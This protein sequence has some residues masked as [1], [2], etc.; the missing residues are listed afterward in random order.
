MPQLIESA[1]TGGMSVDW[2]LAYMELHALVTTV[3]EAEARSIAA[4]AGRDCNQFTV[5]THLATLPKSECNAR[6]LSNTALVCVY[7]SVSYVG[8]WVHTQPSHPA[9]DEP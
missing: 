5:Y 7:D 9:L 2:M 6:V 8:K 3:R 1:N 4:E